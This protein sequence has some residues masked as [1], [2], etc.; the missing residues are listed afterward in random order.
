MAKLDAEYRD[1]TLRRSEMRRQQMHR[2]K[3]RDAE[4]LKAA[5]TDDEVREKLKLTEEDLD[6]L[7][8]ISRGEGKRYDGQTLQALKLKLDFTMK[9]PGEEV[10]VGVR[11][12]FVDLSTYAE[13]PTVT[14]TA[15][16]SSSEAMTRGDEDAGDDGDQV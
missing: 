1:D 3:T 2:K 11:V 16:P 7:R 10:G 13:K 14:V 5:L 9:K 6:T 8:R 4:T 15:L 12:E